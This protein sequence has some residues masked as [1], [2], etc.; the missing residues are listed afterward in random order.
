MRVKPMELQIPETNAVERCTVVDFKASGEIIVRPDKT[1]RRI[2][3]CEFLETSTR[4]H[5]EL[6]RGD[7][8]LVLTADDPEQKGCVLGRIGLY[9]KPDRKHI[10]LDADE[11]LSIR[12][13][14]GS[15][16]IRKNGKI[17]VKGMEIVSHAKGTNRIRGGSIQLN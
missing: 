5:P 16:V 15:I 6:R 9:R 2:I 4:E 1:P 3:V 13:G 7:R 10:T 12:C 11:E 8:V 17:L 14:E